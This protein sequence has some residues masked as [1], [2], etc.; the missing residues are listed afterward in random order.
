MLALAEACIDPGTTRSGSDKA[1]YWGRKIPG[2]DQLVGTSNA[3]GLGIG[4]VELEEVNPHLRRG[5]AENHLGKTTPSSPDRDSNLDIP[6]LSS[7]AQHNKRPAVADNY[8]CIWYGQCNTDTSTGHSQN[9][10]YDGPAKP[11]D[12]IGKVILQKWCPHLLPST[13]D[14]PVSTCC[15][16]KQ[17]QNLDTSITMA[18]GFIQRCP[19]CMRNLAR[20]LC[21]MTCSPSQSRFINVTEV[22]KSKEGKEFVNALE[23]YVTDTYI[24]G[25]YNSCKQVSVPSTGQLAL[26]L[27][28]GDWGASRCS[29][30]KWF[31][32]MGDAHNNPYTPFQ[33]TYVPTNTPVA[34]FIPLDPVITPCNESVSANLPACSCLDCEVSCPVPPPEPAPAAPFIV[35]GIDGVEV[36]M[37]ILFVVGTILF[38]LVVFCWPSG[39]N[40]IAEDREIQV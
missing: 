17:L 20:H 14:E 26:D 11:L 10:L 19:A 28:C 23:L 24:S 39:K 15:D 34:E 6:V 16:T 3:N 25:T 30:M 32:F 35:L 36:I 7:R 37:V 31:T 18:A 12:K 27:M 40:A 29:P 38:L 1:G 33:I 9:C 13:G 5:R 8:H 4:K 2:A 21:D 22:E